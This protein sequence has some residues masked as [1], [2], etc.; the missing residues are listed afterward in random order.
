MAAANGSSVDDTKRKKPADDND[1]FLTDSEDDMYALDREDQDE[2]SDDPYSKETAD[3]ARL[4]MAKEMIAKLEEAGGDEDEASASGEDEDEDRVSRKLR[5]QVEREQGTLQRNAADSIL[6]LDMTAESRTRL[7]RGH[8]LSVTCTDV[9]GDERTV[10]SGSKDCTIIKWDVETGKKLHT[11][12][13]SRKAPNGKGHADEVLALSSSS[14]GRYLASGGRD[15]LVYLWDARSDSLIKTFKSHRDS[16]SGLAF[17]HHTLD[18]FSSSFDRTVN[19][20]NISEM[21]FVETLFG[22]QSPIQGI[23]ALYQNRA[24]TCGGDRTVRLW[25]VADETQLMF[26]GHSSSIDCI[27]MSNEESFFTGSQDGSVSLWSTA[28]KKPHCS[29]RDAH[30]GKWVTAVG[31]RLFSDVVASG[32]SDGYLKLWKSTNNRLSPM[33]A[34]PITGF[35]NSIS[36]SKSGRFLVAG[37]GQEHRLGRWERIQKARNGIRIVSFE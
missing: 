11:F 31:A 10:Y 17:R 15:G 8:R 6:K 30:S 21:T 33:Q 24:L 5:E 2:G 19:V 25:K 14:D 20:W 35:I 22:H 36:F 23:D 34:I 3:E 32:S 12:R 26:N 7:L 18:L 27:K 16:V 4:R 13:D 29:V 1:L 37:V 9:S 28:K